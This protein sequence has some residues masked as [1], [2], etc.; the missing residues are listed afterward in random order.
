ME[1]NISSQVAARQ[2]T[3]HFL[4][5]PGI[6]EKIANNDIKSLDDLIQ[7]LNKHEV[8]SEIVQAVVDDGMSMTSKLQSAPVNKESFLALKEESSKL[9]ASMSSDEVLAEIEAIS[10]VASD[11]ANGKQID[12]EPMGVGFATEN[13][14]D[15]AVAASL[16]EFLSDKG[17][18]VK[19]DPNLSDA[20]RKEKIDN[21]ILG[22]FNPEVLNSAI[23]ALADTARFYQKYVD[24]Q[25]DLE[26]FQENRALAHQSRARFEAMAEIFAPAGSDLS[27]DLEA[28][29]QYAKD[30]SS[31][32]IAEQ[33]MVNVEIQKADAL[34]MNAV[35]ENKTVSIEDV[36]IDALD[37]SKNR[38]LGK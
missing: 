13:N 11:L 24:V 21:I 9:Y 5:T 27:A 6:I 2:L 37:K 23:T 15:N 33:K 26:S 34:F 14:R 29:T 16:I 3:D 30:L 38:G 12:F 25:F 7:D 4:K 35:E 32:T 10:T 28:I 18:Q 19:Y 36:N 22:H 8:A 31:N 20:M 1:N 17:L